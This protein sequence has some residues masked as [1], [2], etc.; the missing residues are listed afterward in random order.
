MMTVGELV[1]QLM[2]HPLDSPV[3]VVVEDEFDSS[4]PADV[5]GT[6]RVVDCPDGPY[7]EVGASL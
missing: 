2:D 1:E 6:T 7:V 3:R 4:P 5:Y